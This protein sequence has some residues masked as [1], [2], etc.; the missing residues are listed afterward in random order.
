ML[1]F[2]MVTTETGCFILIGDGV[3]PVMDIMPFRL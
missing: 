3:V 1:F 2:E